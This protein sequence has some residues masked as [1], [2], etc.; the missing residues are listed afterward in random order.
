[1]TNLQVDVDTQV[2]VLSSK[3]MFYKTENFIKQTKYI[4]SID[5]LLSKFCETIILN[6]DEILKNERQIQDEV[7]CFSIQTKDKKFV[8]MFKFG[9]QIDKSLNKYDIVFFEYLTDK[10]IRQND[11]RINDYFKANS[12]V[13]VQITNA[14]R[15]TS[16]PDFNKLYIISTNS[17][18][19]L[20]KL[21]EQQKEIVE[22][23]DKNVLVQGIAGS[24]K[25]NIC[26]DKIIFNACK[27]FSGKTLYT[28]FSRGLL[29]DTKLKVENFKQDLKNIL[30]C[31]KKKNIIFLDE[32][33]KKALENRL[34]IYFFSQD[35]DQIFKKVEKIV[36]YLSNKVDY[37]LIEDI[38]KNKFCEEKTF[39][40]ENFFIN[41]YCENLKNHQIQ[42][43]FEKLSKYSKE[44]IYKEIFGMIFGT[45]DLNEKTEIMPL[46]D[47][48][49]ARGNSFSKFECEMIYQ[50]AVDFKKYCD[51]NNLI[52][53]NFASRQLIENASNFEYSLSIIDE[54]QD[55]TQVNLCLFKKLSLKLFC[56][57]DALQ[58]INPSYF[59]F[60]YLKNLLFEKDL[61]EV[62][63]LQHNY[64]N[65]AKIESI[66]DALGEVN[67]IEFGTHSFV[68]K[69]H[70]VDNGIKTKAIYVNDTGFVKQIAQSKFDNFTFVVANVAQKKEL[71]ST[72]KNQEVLTVSEI[73]GLERDTVVVYNILSSNK[74]KWEILK[75]NKVNHK[76][77]DENSVFR[78]YYNL[79]YVGVSRAKQNIFVVENSVVSQ[80]KNFFQENFVHKNTSDAVRLL[81]EIVRK[82]DFTQ[83]EVLQR[84]EEFIKQEQFDNARFMASKVR[85]DLERVKILHKIEISQ[86]YIHFGKYREAGIKFWEFGMLNEAKK[87]F[88]LSGD[89]V[90]IDFVDRCSQNNQELNIDIID[91]YDEVKDNK[92][93]RDFIIEMLERDIADLKSG[94]NEIKDNFKKVG[95]RSG[96]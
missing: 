85:D 21:S 25:T 73:K 81:S 64:R 29:V 13:K 60:G 5:F 37:F 1:M 2:V 62:K 82:L 31:N 94:F 11:Q 78:Y 51:K 17:G 33:H 30:E 39:V 84:V 75:Q 38:Y 71:Q 8:M 53:N 12:N 90:L 92:V 74:D 3:S 76:Q 47:Y 44:I 23:V 40:N 49:E 4:A 54:V 65:S 57:G 48:V 93:A 95:N 69:G 16:A 7:A 20:P 43:S 36:D 86:N 19:N 59:N 61:T 45:Y 26:I 6:L 66:I 72:L 27:D 10:Q 34:G 28:T 18:V 55:Y 70:S 80:F 56:V 89:Q 50:I 58:M 35:D 87:Q 41:N 67:K 15:L 42:R 83:Q 32:N 79:F 9:Y 22:T 68:L 24:G 14:K 46:E 88:S 52:D 63:Q 96:K 77:A 91:F